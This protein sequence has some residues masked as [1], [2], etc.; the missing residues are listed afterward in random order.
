MEAVPI[1][2][3]LKTP[4]DERLRALDRYDVLDTPSEQGFDR[5]T[6]IAKNALDVPMAAVSLIDG[7]RQWLKSR[8]G[9][10]ASESCKSQA[11]CNVAIRM[12]EPLIVED[13]TVDPR[14]RTNQLVLGPPFI[15]AYVGVQ[16]Q[17]PD[18]YSL[19]ALCAIDTKPRHFEAK[20]IALL[21][22]L[23]DLVMSEFDALAQARIDSLTGALT[24]RGFRYEAERAIEL[25]SRHRHPLSC[26][27]FDLDH[28]KAINDTHG[29]AAGDRV[30]VKAA[31]VCRE[32]LR[33][34]D[35]FGRLG[36]EEFTI[37]LPHTDTA[38]AVKVAEQIRTE[39]EQWRIPSDPAA[40][41]TGSFG[42]VSC[43]H[44][45]APLDELLRRADLAL[46]AAKEAGRNASVVWQP[47]ADAVN[48][49]HMRR[50]LKA[51]QIVFNSGRSVID[52]SVRGLCEEAARLDV[53][54]TA[55]IPGKFKL[56]IPADGFSRICKVTARQDRKI[57]VTF[58]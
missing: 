16:L 6:R 5:C 24:R 43:Q 12:S 29:H 26:I 54:S 57:E 34:S 15:R 4:E 38:G 7:H 22:D 13:A 11:F 2:V 28:F 42:I 48:A 17:T 18:N 47:P 30:L 31:S 45:D 36:G 25:S 33:S 23:A 37:I 51:G 44:A 56:A 40:R 53:V 3:G 19:G 20:H 32:R 10:L 14:F 9:P 46:Y 41:V 49:G 21:K 55:G 35:I 39:L 50:V 8:Q 27:S 58:A 1:D 52:C